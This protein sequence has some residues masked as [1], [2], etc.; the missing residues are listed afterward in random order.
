MTDL[1][2]RYLE[3]VAGQL[4]AKKRRDITAE[5]RDLILTTIESREAELGR[6]LTRPEE[7]AVLKAQGHPFLVAA[8]YLDHPY[9]IGPSVYPFYV[10]AL[11]VVLGIVAAIYLAAALLYA[12]GLR[13]GPSLEDHFVRDML[14]NFA[15]VTLIAWA[16][17]RTGAG[18]KLAAGWKPSR[19]PA[20][21]VAG[22]S[23]FEVAFEAAFA[24][25]F[26]LWWLGVVHFPAA[27]YA[28]RVSWALAPVWR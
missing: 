23:R 10:F 26:I 13:G 22:R 28:D 6:P 7:E 18:R 20:V 17:E 5:L 25:G 8:G 27:P 24:M 11:K 4:P 14:L 2:D 19:L 3:A 1:T 15:I 16:A 12:I 9:M 21:P